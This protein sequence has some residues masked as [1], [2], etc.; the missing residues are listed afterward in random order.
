M[1]L[2]LPHVGP[3][4]GLTQIMASG[5]KTYLRILATR[6]CKLFRLSPW[7]GRRSFSLKSINLTEVKA[8]YGILS[9]LHL[10]KFLVDSLSVTV[11]TS[12]VRSEAKGK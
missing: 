4:G 11:L 2:S 5:M 9:F 12:M 6:A 1:G 8:S 10:I 3:Y 7:E